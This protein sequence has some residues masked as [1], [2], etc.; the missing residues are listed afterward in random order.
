MMTQNTRPSLLVAATTLLTTACALILISDPLPVYIEG[1]SLAGTT[2]F[3]HLRWNS[4]FIWPA[5]LTSFVA[6]FSTSFSSFMDGVGALLIVSGRALLALPRGGEEKRFHSLLHGG[7]L[8]VLT[9]VVLHLVFGRDTLLIV[10]LATVPWIV[11]ALREAN[12]RS[13]LLSYIICAGIVLVSNLLLGPLG[14]PVAIICAAIACLLELPSENNQ[15]GTTHSSRAILWCILF[16]PPLLVSFYNG[17]LPWNYPATA[18]LV[19][20]DGVPGIVRPLV[21]PDTPIP[22]LDRTALKAALAPIVVPIIVLALWF[23]TLSRAD[24]GDSSPRRRFAG[25]LLLLA[26]AL[27]WDTVFHERW[28]EIGPLAALE[29][30]LPGTSPIGLAPLTLGVS[31]MIALALGSARYGSGAVLLVVGILG[32]A[33]VTE[34]P[35]RHGI[36]GASP[37]LFRAESWRHS[38]SEIL[39]GLDRSARERVLASPSLAVMLASTPDARSVGA[40]KSDVGF[41]RMPADLFVSANADQISHLRDHDPS[42][43]WTASSG[44]QSGA[45]WIAVRF[46]EPHLLD[47]LLLDTGG[48]TTDFPQGLRFSLLD[49]CPSGPLSADRSEYPWRSILSTP[50]W[51]GPFL[52]TSADLPYFGNQSDVRVRFH[53]PLSV[54]CLLIEQTG[55]RPV[56]DW[57]IAEL[58][59]FP[60]EDR[61]KN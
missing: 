10:S 38:Q 35:W 60:H 22:F 53:E 17:E 2:S 47:G 54:R 44:G 11:L 33:F 58:R 43:R 9:T 46:H 28:S 50:Q 41:R 56:F 25:M 57:S 48:F 42:T 1:S 7:A 16:I 31:L 4:V 18:H 59:F 12:R 24:D 6:I 55:V 23:F 5:W 13:S 61:V 19:P 21:G 49:S 20:D 45:E 15:G 26:A 29:R 34:S 51:H 40:L 36:T 27:T 3:V 37:L 14:L 8:G 32:G 39:F 52:L 30:I